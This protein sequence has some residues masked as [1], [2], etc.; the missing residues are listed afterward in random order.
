MPVVSLSGD[1]VK[2][3]KWLDF[4]LPIEGKM[5]K[6]LNVVSQY[7]G[8]NFDSCNGRPRTIVAIE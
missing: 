1:H 6:T 2:V 7:S 5:F 3:R 4:F 8:A